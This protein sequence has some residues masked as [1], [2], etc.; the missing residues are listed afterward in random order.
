MEWIKATD[1]LPEDIK[2]I[3]PDYKARKRGEPTMDLWDRIYS[4]VEI[5]EST[6]CWEWQGYKRNGYGR[7]TIGSR[8]NGTRRSECTHRISYM[9]NYGEI[10]KGM[11]VCHKCDN[12]SCINPK[13]LFLGTPRDNAVDCLNKGR[14]HD[15]SGENKHNAKLTKTDV[16]NIR[17]IY[18]LKELSL[19]EL[20]RKYN[21][22]RKTMWNAITGKTWKCVL[23]L[24]YKGKNNDTERA[25]D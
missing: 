17:K 24:P 19:R 9:L 1:R 16:E 13:H 5:N 8:T 21:V 4:K 14:R 12:P 15:I 2:P 18:E 20:A 10:P 7:T 25:E 3:V 6:G 22:N 11:D 23:Y